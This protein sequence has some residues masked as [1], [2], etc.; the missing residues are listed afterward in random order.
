MSFIIENTSGAPFALDE[1][2]ITIGTG[3]QSDL[4]TQAIPQDIAWSSQ[5]GEELH[6]AISNGDIV[7]KDPSDGITN[8]SIVD[9]IAACQTINT[10]Q[11]YTAL[12]VAPGNEAEIEVQDEGI[13][14]T[15]AVTKL[16][17]VGAG[18]VAT[19]P[20][21]DEIT[22]TIAGGGS[23]VGVSD[24]GTAVPNGP[25]SLI[26]FVGDG[27][28]ATDGGS[29]TAT[30]TIPG[31]VLGEIPFFNQ[32]TTQDNIALTGGSEIPFFNQDTTQD[33]IAL[34]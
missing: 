20:V 26:N 32:D 4:S 33:N 15:P 25:F 31:S 27:V 5:P 12:H 34:V 16:N 18:V 9:G 2:G 30:V 11:S 13:S 7:V 28:D 17:F 19:E 10:P 14:L 24:E 8:L 3:G 6:T 29:G 21:A 22:V 1:F 23:G